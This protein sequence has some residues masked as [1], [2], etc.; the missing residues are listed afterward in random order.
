MIAHV[1][2]RS[3]LAFGGAL[4]LGAPPLRAQGT[5]ILARLRTEKKVK[6]G[7]ANQPPFSALNPDDK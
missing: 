7:F 3:V 4:L 2:R 6:V 5:G 1:S